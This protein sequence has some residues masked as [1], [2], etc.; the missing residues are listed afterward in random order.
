MRRSSALAY[1]RDG[2]RRIDQDG[3]LHVPDCPIS[4]AVVNPYRGSEIPDAEALGLDPDR[5]YYLLRD[6]SA[7]AEGADTFSGIPLL[8]THIPVSADD[9][10][11]QSVV[12]AVS[13]ARFEAPYLV[14]D[15]VVWD[16]EAIGHIED[17]S[18]REL[19]AAYRY[20]P[21]MESGTFEGVRYDGRMTEIVGNHVALVPEG[22]AGSDV[23]VADSIER[24]LARFPDYDR[25]LFTY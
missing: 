20:T 12:G 23:V 9:P 1:D 10:Q 24:L 16:A 18:Q 6:P 3:R 14:A 11:K 19:S 15:L 25:L 13:N 2:A 22:R 5:V 4:K 8:S 7:L 21:V 17:G